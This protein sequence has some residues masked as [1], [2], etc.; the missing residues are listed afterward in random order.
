MALESKTM[1]D[2]TNTKQNVKSSPK[3]I[4][5]CNL[6]PDEIIKWA[7]EA[8][9][10][11]DRRAAREE[12][13]AGPGP[14]R[15]NLSAD[16]LLLL[17]ES[18][19]SRGFLEQFEAVIESMGGRIEEK[20]LFS[21]EGRGGGAIRVHGNGDFTI[22]H[23]DG[24][25]PTMRLWNIAH[26]LGHY[27]LH[28]YDGQKS[29]F[30]KQLGDSDEAGLDDEEKQASDEANNQADYFAAAFLMP[31]DRFRAAKAALAQ[32]GDGPRNE[33]ERYALLAKKFGVWPVLVRQWDELLTQAETDS[34]EISLHVG[35][36]AAMR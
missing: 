33:R 32:D 25:G 31:P 8:R 6:S 2:D 1:G 15:N 14:D 19:S 17:S 16:E 29:F 20:P 34:Q 27:Y 18:D 5:P 11:F 21:E 26:E 24:D 12:D 30:A 4:R 10:I 35:T 3:G 7:V 9:E 23:L 22:Y 28:V 13:T 36:A